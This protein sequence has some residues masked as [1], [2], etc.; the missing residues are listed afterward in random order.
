MGHK[1]IVGNAL[2]FEQTFLTQEGHCYTGLIIYDFYSC[3]LL[4]NPNPALVGYKNLALKGL[5]SEKL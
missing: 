1:E 3:K 2:I 5:I 4:Q